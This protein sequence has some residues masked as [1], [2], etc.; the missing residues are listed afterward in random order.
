MGRAILGCTWVSREL[1]IGGAPVARTTITPPE[2]TALLYDRVRRAS[3]P[4]FACI[5]TLALGAALTSCTFVVPGALRTESQTIRPDGASSARIQLQMAAGELRVS[6]GADALVD[7]VFTYNVDSWRPEVTYSV[8]D[9]V[10]TL[11]IQQPSESNNLPSTSMGT[12]RNEWDLRL[13]GDVPMDLKIQLGA[14][15][16]NL[17]LGGM[18]LE[19]LDVQTGAGEVNLDLTG[20][21]TNDLVAN[22][23]GGVGQ[24]TVR[25]PRDVGVRVDAR[26]GLGQITATGLEQNGNIYVND[27][28]GESP[29]TLSLSIE[30]GIGEINLVQ[31]D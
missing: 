14:G 10:G 27:A 29:V 8:R 18:R 23:R 21:W 15:R 9:E 12:M 1:F 7:A 13:D 22:V 26:G 5:V 30:G 6:P 11:S 16:S 3:G 4:L 25:L 28:L 19:S 2:E 24:V 31:G 20:R 17:R